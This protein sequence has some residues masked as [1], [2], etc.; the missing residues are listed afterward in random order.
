MTQKEAK[1]EKA[2]VSKRSKKLKKQNL[3]KKQKLFLK[4]KKAET[5]PLIPAANNISNKTKKEE[6]FLKETMELDR[7]LQEKMDRRENLI[8]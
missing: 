4:A 6:E 2:K 3:K 7:F 1:A 5:T 8:R